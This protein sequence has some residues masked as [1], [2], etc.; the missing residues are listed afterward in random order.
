MHELDGPHCSDLQQSLGEFLQSSVVIPGTAEKVGDHQLSASAAVEVSVGGHQLT[1]AE[2][3]SRAREAFG[4]IYDGRKRRDDY[5][6]LAGFLGE[7]SQQGLLD[8]GT[9]SRKGAPY[10]KAMAAWLRLYGFESI[11]KKK[12]DLSML[13]RIAD[14][15]A[16]I[17]AWLATVEKERLPFLNHPQTIISHW[18]RSLNPADRSGRKKDEQR[19]SFAAVWDA[20]EPEEITAKLDKIGRAGLCAAMSTALRAEFSDRQAAIDIANA[21]TSSATAVTFSS[22]LHKALATEHEA[23]ILAAVN[24][25]RAKLRTNNLH[26]C[27]LIV[28]LAACGKPKRRSMRRK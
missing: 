27:D 15:M 5:F 7:G 14:N 28:G 3:A 10:H 9:N 23:E 25:L 12:T 8:A 19:P 4:R 17:T 24:A 22:I 16:A 18:Q 26:V 6:T 13:L 2:R 21:D 1:L 11:L 20:A